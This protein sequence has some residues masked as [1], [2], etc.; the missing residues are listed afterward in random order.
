V[1]LT[2]KQ[3]KRW[4]MLFFAVVI[5]VVAA[6]ASA[7]TTANVPV[8]PQFLS[9]PLSFDWNTNLT[10]RIKLVSNAAQSKTATLTFLPYVQ[11]MPGAKGQNGKGGIEAYQR[12]YQL[13]AGQSRSFSFRL[14][15]WDRPLKDVYWCLRVLIE[16]PGAAPQSMDTCASPAHK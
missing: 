14:R 8:Q 4:M 10:Y 3:A 9:S 11:L 13:D 7:A 12:H 15:T 16:V 6:K 2:R 1:F 5:L